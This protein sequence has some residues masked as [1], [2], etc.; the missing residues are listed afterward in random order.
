MR[1]HVTLSAFARFYTPLIVLFACTILAVTAPGQGVGVIAGFAFALALAVHI[2]VF[3]ADAARAGASPAAMRTLLSLGLIAA[4]IGVGIPGLPIALQLAEAGA[5]MSTAACAALI[6]T[7][8]VGRAP[9]MRDE[10]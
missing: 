6:L 4:F 2:L 8:L 10:Q 9:T 1:S 5:F 7:V 3:G